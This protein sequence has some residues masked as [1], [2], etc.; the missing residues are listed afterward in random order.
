VAGAVACVAAVGAL[1]WQTA[2]TRP[3][4][5]VVLAAMI[6]LAVTIEGGYRLTN[7]EMRLHD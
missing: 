7:R 1:V 4:G 5:L 2:Q 6:A 3:F